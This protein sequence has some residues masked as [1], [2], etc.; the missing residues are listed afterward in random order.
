MAKKK[1]AKR[2]T[3]KVS[4]KS[5]KKTG[6]ADVQFNVS[7]AKLRRIQPK[8]ETVCDFDIETADGEVVYRREFKDSLSPELR[9]QLGV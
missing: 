9:Q 3:R 6:A 1:T 7:T 5:K 8:N 4:R 2:G